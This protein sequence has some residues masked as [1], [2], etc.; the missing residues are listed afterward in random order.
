MILN[1]NIR[2]ICSQEKNTPYSLLQ[3]IYATQLGEQLATLVG[4]RNTQQPHTKAHCATLTAR[5]LH[6]SS[7]TGILQDALLDKE[8]HSPSTLYNSVLKAIVNSCNKN[9]HRSEMDTDCESKQNAIHTKTIRTADFRNG[10]ATHVQSVLDTAS[11]LESCDHEFNHIRCTEAQR[12]LAHF[13]LRA[14]QY[15]PNEEL[16]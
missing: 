2:Q 3:Y 13:T 16:Y 4:V 15:R 14:L 6:N 7:F 11:D 8:W 1:R 5:I 12:A 10:I 9:S